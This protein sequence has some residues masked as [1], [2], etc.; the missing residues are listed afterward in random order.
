ME[1]NGIRFVSGGVV[2]FGLNG[3]I[4]RQKFVENGYIFKCHPDDG[5]M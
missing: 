3:Y 4:K 1:G 2:A 5:T